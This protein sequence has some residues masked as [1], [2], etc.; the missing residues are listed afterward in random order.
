MV[1]SRIPLLAL[2]VVALAVAAPAGALTGYGVAGQLHVATLPALT[3]TKAE[4][5]TP[6]R[7]SPG[8]RATG[9]RQT[10]VGTAK[11]PAVV[12]CEQ[13]PRSTVLTQGLKQAGDRRP[14]GAR[15]ALTP[16]RVRLPVDREPGPVGRERRGSR[17]G[18]TR[19]RGLLVRPAEGPV[20]ARDELERLDD[21]FALEIVAPISFPVA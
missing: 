18:A 15:L 2:I 10:L 14:R 9:T 4:Q 8:T 6:A 17:A 20:G 21:Q 11:K 7:P 19:P 3:A 13:P 16:H 12:A 5:R 1:P